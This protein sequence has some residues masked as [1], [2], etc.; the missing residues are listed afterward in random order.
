MYF[1]GYLNQILV[2][3]VETGRV[4]GEIE[5]CHAER[6]ERELLLLVLSDPGGSC[7]NS[8]SVI[9]SSRS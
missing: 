6:I 3:G 7:R 8:R 5:T 9:P 2:T 1:T 4:G